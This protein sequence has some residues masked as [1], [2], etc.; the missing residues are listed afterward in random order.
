[1]PEP[2]QLGRMDV[3]RG[4]RPLPKLGGS[5]G[6]VGVGVG[7]KD[8]NQVVRSKTVSYQRSNQVACSGNTA[9]VDQNRPRPGLRKN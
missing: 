6:V 2:A 5:P 4:P 3:D 9:R 7:E 1:L 8:G